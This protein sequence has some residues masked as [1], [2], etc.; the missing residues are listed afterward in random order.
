MAAYIGLLEYTKYIQISLPCCHQQPDAVHQ[1]K[2]IQRLNT[3]FRI[4]VELTIYIHMYAYSKNVVG[5]N[6]L[7]D[8]CHNIESTTRKIVNSTD[9][10]W[11]QWVS[12]TTRQFRH[13]SQWL[14]PWIC[15]P[16]GFSEWL[17]S[18]RLSGPA[19]TGPRISCSS[20]R[21]AGS[22]PLRITG[23]GEGVTGLSLHSRAPRGSG[24]T[25]AW[26]TTTTTGATTTTS[27]ATDW[28]SH[29]T[30][31]ASANIAST[32]AHSHPTTTSLQTTT[33]LSQSYLISVQRPIYPQ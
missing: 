16:L 10:A 1:L 15:V 13:I 28:V 3:N 2:N 23:H 7:S 24:T 5:Y 27:T 26:T 20:R 12:T 17:L 22:H 30:H 25:A 32:T 11:R 31:H 14:L 6:P 4:Y 33:S 29:R 19:V 18:Y 9:R 8:D 21:S